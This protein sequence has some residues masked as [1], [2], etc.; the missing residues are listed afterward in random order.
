MATEKQK[1]AISNVV[2]NGGNVSRAM[3]DAGYSEQTAKN[4]SKL[5]DSKAWNELMDKYLP[6]KSLAKIH[7]EGLKA[8]TNKPH[9]IDRDDKGRPVYDYI[10]EEDYQTRHRYLDT[11]YKLKGK[12]AADKIE[13]SGIILTL[14]KEIAEQNGLNEITSDNSPG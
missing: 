8:T 4:P 2:E 11:A 5:T 7:N 13:H 3:K 9:L 10:P 1:K 12:Y 6:D 14:E